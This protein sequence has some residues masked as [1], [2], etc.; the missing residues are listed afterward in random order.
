MDFPKKGDAD[1][2]DYLD[3]DKPLPGQNFACLS[4]VC[5]EDVIKKKEDFYMNSFLTNLSQE[6]N[7]VE[8]E[9]YYI[10]NFLKKI[11]K[12]HNID[13]DSNL[14][15]GYLKYIEDEADELNSSYKKENFIINDFNDKYSTYLSNN[16][17]K[18]DEVFDSDNNFKTSI[19]GV[20]VR[21]VFA[22]QKE[23]EIRSKVLQKLDKNFHVY[24]APVGY[25]LPMDPNVNEIQ[26]QEY[27]ESELNNLVKS[28]KE[29]EI[30]KEEF[31][32]EQTHEKV[33]EINKKNA[34]IKEKMTEVVEKKEEVVEKKEVSEHQN[35]LNSLEENDPWM[36]RKEEEKNKKK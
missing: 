22:T 20:K 9:R 33:K 18:L 12:D 24:V 28:Y 31:F 16:K 11:Q 36:S 30:K 1:Y 35:I 32:T 17:V 6:Q 4:F 29:N 19:R 13:V 23:A 3:E 21:G 14:F 7:F 8:R 27:A 15:N 10:N 2:V 5:P 34:E 26:N 25:W